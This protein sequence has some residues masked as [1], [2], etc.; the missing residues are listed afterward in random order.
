M[1]WI[2]L[3]LALMAALVISACGS[4]PDVHK[5]MENLGKTYGALMKAVSETNLG[6]ARQAFQVIITEFE[7][8]S[9]VKPRKGTKE[10]W[11]SMHNAIIADAKKG[12]EAA[13]KNDYPAVQ[14]SV[15]NIGA[16]IKPAH[17]VFR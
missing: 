4:G 8:L 15:S 5:S 1:K 9:N 11:D 3:P 10:Q 7:S 6:T 13:D 2:L 14:V 17:Q 16:S 12:I